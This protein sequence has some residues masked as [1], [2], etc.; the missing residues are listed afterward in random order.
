MVHKGYKS[1]LN[2]VI[3][4]LTERVQSNLSSKIIED[5]DFFRSFKEI[6]DTKIKHDSQDSS[7][8]I[9]QIE[10]RIYIQLSKLFEEGNYFDSKGAFE[11]VHKKLGLSSLNSLVTADEVMKIYQKVVYLA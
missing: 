5:N 11:I 9:S 3:S 1:S 6:K 2:E 8:C 4:Q 7:N 10:N